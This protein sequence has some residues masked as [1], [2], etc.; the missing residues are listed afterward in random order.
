MPIDPSIPLSVKPPEFMSPAQMITLRNLS[1]QSQLQ[2]LQMAEAQRQQQVRGVYANPQ[3]RD[4]QTGT[5]SLQGIEQLAP[6]SPEAYMQA[7]Q[8]RGVALSHLSVE[9]QRR[10]QRQQ[11]QQ[12]VKDGIGRDALNAY[13]LSMQSGASDEVAMRAMT[14]ARNAAVDELWKSG[15]AASLGFTDQ[16]RQQATSAPP[17]PMKLRAHLFTP[18]QLAQR[19]ERTKTPFQRDL[20][21]FQKMK[22]GDPGYKEMKARVERETAPTATQL[23]L[24]PGGAPGG[25]GSQM[26]QDPNTGQKYMVNNRS[27]KAWELDDEGLWKATNPNNLPKNLQKAGGIGTAGARESVFTQ[28]LIQAG[29]QA[30]KDLENV[31]KLPIKVTRGP[32]G[33]FGS[34]TQPSFLDAGKVALGNKM[35]SEDSQVYNAMSTG[36]QRTLAAIESAGLM[37]SGSLTHQMDAVIFKPGDTELAKLHKLAQTRQIVESGME[38]I[39]TNPRI[40]DSEKGIVRNIVQRLQKAVPFTHSDLI[41]LSRK[42]QENPEATMRDVMKSRQGTDAPG[43]AYSDPEKEKRYQEWKKANGG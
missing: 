43:G 35:T 6:I 17:D 28:R 7:G 22:P 13:D 9:E 31:V 38:V 2:E 42:Q 30:S 36:F 24:G 25:A 39:L 41:E 34:V 37:P 20:D 23:Q 29:N 16:D 1:R 3:N 21:R 32:F 40:S 18:E 4:Q 5:L 14:E 27:G 12:K 10:S 19:E 15:R 11:D 8:Q 33:A 26:M